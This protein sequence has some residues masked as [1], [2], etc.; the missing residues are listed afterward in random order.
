M[1]IGVEVQDHDLM[2]S[3]YDSKG[4]ISYIKKRLSDH[5]IFNWVEHDKPSLYKNWDGGNIKQ[6]KSDPRWLTRT[7]LEELILEKLTPEEHELLY[8]FDNLPK[9]DYIDIEILLTSDEFP[10][11]DKVEMP[12][13]IISFCNEDGV[14]Y[15]L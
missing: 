10:A 9:I 15:V 6:E 14:I 8:S 13:G 4:K 1:I 7:R 11:P 12:D 2:I 5:E 3:Y